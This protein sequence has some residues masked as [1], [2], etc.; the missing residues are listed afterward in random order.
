MLRPVPSKICIT[1]SDVERVKSRLAHRPTHHAIVA[2]IDWFAAAVSSQNL[3]PP[4]YNQGVLLCR[5]PQRH[6]RDAYVR[7]DSG[8]TTPLSA[9]T[10]SA[11]RS[12]YLDGDDDL[13][14]EDHQDPA[15]TRDVAIVNMAEARRI[16]DRTTTGLPFQHRTDNFTSQPSPGDNDFGFSD[17]QQLPLSYDI[18]THL[19]LDGT[20]DPALLSQRGGDN[21]TPHGPTRLSNTDLLN[22]FGLLHL[23]NVGAADDFSIA[24]S[25]DPLAPSFVPRVRFGSAAD[26]TETQNASVPTSEDN[27][28]RRPRQQTASSRNSDNRQTYSAGARFSNGAFPRPPPQ[29]RNVVRDRHATGRPRLPIRGGQAFATP[30]ESSG[31]VLDRYHAVAYRS[32]SPMPP[33][34]SSL[35]EAQELVDAVPRISHSL[36]EVRGRH[37]AAIQSQSPSWTA[38]TMLPSASHSVPNLSNPAYRG[39]V[40]HSRHSSLSWNRNASQVLVQASSGAPGR[41]SVESA[42]PQS[43]LNHTATWSGPSPAFYL[44]HSPLDEL[45]DGLQYFSKASSAARLSS[46]GT[47][48]YPQPFRGRLL[49]GSLFYAEETRSDDPALMRHPFQDSASAP[50]PALHYVSSERS[51]SRDEAAITPPVP[52]SS[53]CTTAQ[54][55][56][57]LLAHQSSGSTACS[58]SSTLPNISSPE[59]FPGTRRASPMNNKPALSP[60]LSLLPSDPPVSIPHVSPRIIH[61]RM[62]QTDPFEAFPSE[63]HARLPATP[64]LKVYDDELP[65]TAQPQTP[66]D[67]SAYAR[68]VVIPRAKPEENASPVIQGVMNPNRETYPSIRSHPLLEPTTAELIAIP[69]LSPLQMARQSRLPGRRRRRNATTS[70]DQENEFDPHDILGLD[71][72]RRNWMRNRAD[73]GGPGQY[74]HRQG[75]TAQGLML[76]VTPPREGRFERMM[77]G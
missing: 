39:P 19:A 7:L 24:N 70:E 9:A 33:T 75:N 18:S 15:M 37:T 69:F 8:N 48:D 12:G 46:G 17:S 28:L 45:T 11:Y 58:E 10:E 54:P 32:E 42:L 62:K 57:T 49:S 30:T 23:P 65:A 27:G 20:T 29:G 35:S 3:R 51:H 56:S 67:L 61:R 21:A 47:S 66:A 2:G 13:A 55:Q 36:Q 63:A 34:P 60:S 40:V 74:D 22:E 73:I 71:A 5:G 52:L 38:R 50:Q 6:L 44:N 26:N 1:N 77:R 59:P 41:P 4:R 68:A 43:P 25:L 31:I 16:I 72:E 53:R 76:D 14:Y 64:R